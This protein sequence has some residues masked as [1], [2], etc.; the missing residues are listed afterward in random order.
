MS[1]TRRSGPLPPT[2]P[3]RC[4]TVSNSNPTT[5]TPRKRAILEGLNGS[6]DEHDEQVYTTA[7]STPRVTPK[8]HGTAQ[9]TPARR[10]LFSE[11]T[12][13]ASPF[14][15][16][17][18]RPFARASTEGDLRSRLS[19]EE[20]CKLIDVRDKMVEAQAERISAM[21]KEIDALKEERQISHSPRLSSPLPSPRKAENRTPEFVIPG[22]S[23]EPITKLSIQSHFPPRSPSTSTSTKPAVMWN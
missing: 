23:D 19:K 4:R 12:S 16:S 9:N 6:V 15:S 20:L 10:D 22:R 21:Q 11:S 1:P 17:S 2:T 8:K 14:S 13:K 7:S 3:T 18:E 5:D